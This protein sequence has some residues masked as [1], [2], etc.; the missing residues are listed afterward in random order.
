MRETADTDKSRGSPEKAEKRGYTLVEIM[1]AVGLIAVLAVMAIP[2]LQLV[3][4]NALETSAIQGLKEL[5]QAEELYYDVF[6]YY[7]A[8]HDQWHDLRRVD[9]IDAKSYQRL[10]GRR[11]I[12]I[13]GYSVQLTNMGDYPQNYSIIAWPLETGMDLKTF[14][15]V[16]DGIVRDWGDPHDRPITI[17]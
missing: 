10:S 12:F 7:T 8:G 5:S 14:F 2:N 17:Y 6:G 13:R 15:I 9:A 16:G 3:R 1:L 4:R 11:G